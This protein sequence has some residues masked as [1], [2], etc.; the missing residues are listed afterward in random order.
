MARKRKPG[1][2]SGRKQKP[3]ARS[4]PRWPWLAGGFALGLVAA[5]VLYVAERLAP[6]AAPE[7]EPSPAEAA[8]ADQ[9]LGEREPGGVTPVPGSTVEARARS[10]EGDGERRGA[11]RFEFYEL[12]PEFEV[13]VPEVEWRTDTGP[14]PA[15]VEEP[16]RYVLQVGSFTKLADADRMKA[17]LALLGIESRLQ[18]V[19]V[20]DK[21]FHRVRIGPLSDLERINEIRNQLREERIDSLLMRAP[22]QEQ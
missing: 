14:P 8:P 19:A 5:G 20:D 12:L 10:E 22:A 9:T 4:A 11:S 7:P 6:L 13:V 1:R 16:G 15:E 3:Q 17:N 18:R 21:V 2:Q